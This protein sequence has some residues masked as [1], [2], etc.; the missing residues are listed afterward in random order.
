M[1]VTSE[2]FY[3]YSARELI[4]MKLGMDDYVLDSH[5]FGISDAMHFKFCVMIQNH[6]C[7]LN[8]F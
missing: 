6:I 2:A 7:Y 3:Y 8:P 4:N 1:V 5:I